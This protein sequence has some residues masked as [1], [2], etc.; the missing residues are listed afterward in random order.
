MVSLAR[1]SPIEWLV[2]C[3]WNRRSPRCQYQQRKDIVLPC[4]IYPCREQLA[5]RPDRSR[6]VNAFNML[7][8]RQRIGTLLLSVE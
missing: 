3:P 2:N 4:G 8:D 5:T 7:N 1:L 6:C